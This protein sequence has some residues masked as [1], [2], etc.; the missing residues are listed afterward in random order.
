MLFSSFP[1]QI[2]LLQCVI[3]GNASLAAH[4]LYH[5]LKSVIHSH[6]PFMHL[7]VLLR[8]WFLWHFS[9]LLAFFFRSLHFS[10]FG[11]LV[12]FFYFYSILALFFFLFF[13]YVFLCFQ[14]KGFCDLTWQGFSVG[15]GVSSPIFIT[16]SLTLLVGFHSHFAFGLLARHPDVYTYKR[17]YSNCTHIYKLRGRGRG[18]SAVINFYGV[19]LISHFSG[20]RCKRGFMGK[21]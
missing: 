19:N 11:L 17:V 3:Y 20:F 1:I 13:F 4:S 6:R 14:L 21:M 9:G 10:T 5:S 18:Q 8:V 15:L 16:P 2:E 7:F 12:A